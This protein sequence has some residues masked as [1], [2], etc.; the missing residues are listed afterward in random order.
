MAALST[1]GAVAGGTIGINDV[2]TL[3]ATKQSVIWEIPARIGTLTVQVAV[4]SAGGY[5][6]EITASPRD[7]VVSDTADWFD[8]FGA[9]Q[10]ASRQQALFASVTAVKFTRVSGEHR[11]CIRGQ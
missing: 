3:N 9:D 7:N 10:V 8:V 11:V 4:L 1:P 5:R 6:V 2:T